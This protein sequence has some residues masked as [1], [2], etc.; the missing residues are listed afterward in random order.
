[1]PPVVRGP[2]PRECFRCLNQDLQDARLKQDGQDGQ[3]LQDLQDGL[4]VR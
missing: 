2:V 4:Q 3:D 1:M